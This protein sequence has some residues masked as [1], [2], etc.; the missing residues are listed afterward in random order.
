[1]KVEL[2]ISLVKRWLRPV[3]RHPALRRRSPRTHGLV[4]GG[5]LE[6][7]CSRTQAYPANPG[8]GGSSLTSQELRVADKITDF[9]RER[10]LQ[11]A[12][13]RYWGIGAM[14]ARGGVKA[15]DLLLRPT[16]QSSQDEFLIYDSKEHAIPKIADA[17]TSVKYEYKIGYA[18]HEIRDPKMFDITTAAFCVYFEVEALGRATMPCLSFVTLDAASEQSTHV[19]IECY[20]L[21]PFNSKSISMYWVKSVRNSINSR[22]P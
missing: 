5:K 22:F 15:A 8:S 9:L 14:L 20:S 6:K 11:N 1:M 4:K 17:I 16:L 2:A 3:V 7:G 18:K 12:S 21:A 13:R 19:I 10:A